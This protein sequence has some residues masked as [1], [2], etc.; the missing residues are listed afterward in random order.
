MPVVDRPGWG[1]L[2]LQWSAKLIIGLAVVAALLS[3]RKSVQRFVQQLIQPAADQRFGEMN[4]RKC[5]NSGR[6]SG[7]VASAPPVIRRT[8]NS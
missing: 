5:V 3:V 1:G 6:G 2:S 8:V 4:H 7:P